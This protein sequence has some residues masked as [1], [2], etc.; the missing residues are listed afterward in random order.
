M[1]FK[2][3]WRN[4][5]MKTTLTTALIT[6]VALVGIVAHAQH[7]PPDPAKMVQRHVEFLTEKLGLSS[8]QQQQATTIFTNASANAKTLHDQMQAAHQNL[9][10]AVQKNDN[11][12]IEQAAN[13]LGNL[14]AQATA[15]HGKADAAFYQTLTPDQQSKFSEMQS[16]GPGMRAFGGHH[17]P[18]F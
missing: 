10:A 17:G 8:A 7:Q 5:P 9:Q 12:G 1:V 18:Q 2:R 15:A 6:V 13:T 16:H 14:M 3:K 4:K 11:A